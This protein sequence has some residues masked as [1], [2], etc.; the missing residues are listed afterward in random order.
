LFKYLLQKKKKNEVVIKKLVIGPLLDK[1]KRENF[2]G[3]FFFYIIFGWWLFN[4][5][6]LVSV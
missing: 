6:Q 2:E 4:G 1:L 3:F 5:M